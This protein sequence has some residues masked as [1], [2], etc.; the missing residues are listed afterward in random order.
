MLE[1]VV[2]RSTYPCRQLIS[3]YG[4][5]KVLESIVAA[6]CLPGLL[7]IP[8]ARCWKRVS[9]AH[10][11][12]SRRSND[13]VRG[14]AI[15]YRYLRSFHRARNTYLR[16]TCSALSSLDVRYTTSFLVPGFAPSLAAGFPSSFSHPG[17][18]ATRH[19]SLIYRIVQK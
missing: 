13:D 3:F 12:G 7:G 16:R 6:L 8:S 1:N 10:S 15:Q 9:R 4:I 18:S 14:I 17:R 5:P 11:S 19:V 2:L